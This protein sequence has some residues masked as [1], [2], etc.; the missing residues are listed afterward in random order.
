MATAS[1]GSRPQIKRNTRCIHSPENVA[2]VGAAYPH[3]FSPPNCLALLARAI[4]D[5]K[6]KED[7]NVDDYALECTTSMDRFV[8]EAL[9]V[10]T[11]GHDTLRLII[12]VITTAAFETGLKPHIRV[13]MVREDCTLDFQT[14][15]ARAKKHE[16]NN[17]RS[18]PNQTGDTSHVSAATVTPP[19][20]Q[21]AELIADQ[22]TILTDLQSQLK[23]IRGERGRSE[24][25]RS[26]RDRSESRSGETKRVRFRDSGT[27]STSKGNEPSSKSGR[28]N[29][30]EYGP[31]RYK[32]THDT[33]DCRLMQSHA[34]FAKKF[35]P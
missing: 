13:E 12:D 5:I 7:Q 14:A 1:G 28:G 6:R 24:K 25:R 16:Q 19:K 2:T 17:L 29:R 32:S 22:G 15:T 33:A 27:K 18:W 4:A 9:R 31:C 30:C 3:R 23:E 20:P 11:P 35:I 21:L 10:K 26:S 8:T 34:E